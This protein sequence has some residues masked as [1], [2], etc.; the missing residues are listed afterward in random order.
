MPIKIQ[1]SLPAQAILENENIFVMTE[2]RAMHQDIRPLN[3][4]I[5]N[6]MPTKE[7]TETQLLRKL[8][9]S[10]LQV[11]IELLQTASYTPTHVDVT[12]LDSFYTTFDKVKD[13]KFDGMII[14]GAP[15][16]H[17]DYEDVAYW[18]EL[19]Q[20]MKWSEKHVHCT[21]YLC[22]GAFAGLYY[23]YGIKHKFYDRKL[24]GIFEHKVLKPTSPLFRGFDD[25]FH[26]PQSREIY[27]TR[28][29]IL[30]VPG[31]ELMADSDE[32]GVTIVKT[33][34]S[35]KFFVTCH[36]E[37]DAD[38]LANEYNRDLG[39]GLNP[40]IPA[41]YFPDDDPAKAPI[42]N[43]RSTGQLLY[44]NWLNYYVYQSVPYDI[45]EIGSE[46]QKK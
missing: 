6:L 40:D 29:Q 38:T 24:S 20:I 42:V 12:H 13:R 34:D 27:V 30:S 26:A 46:E 22:W 37:Y 1:D 2:Y 7:V 18:D 31:L 4:L 3:V 14:T 36:A 11:N 8:S 41:N 45:E 17:I 44:T 28:E 21:Y 33:E 5:L 15:L 19:C 25:V 39:K 43:W 9:N 35:R 10:P 16:E 32:A 23:F